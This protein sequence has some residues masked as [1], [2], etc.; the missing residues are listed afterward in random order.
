MQVAQAYEVGGAAA[1]SVLTEEQFFG[2][3]LEDLKDARAA[4]LLP[5]LRKDFV[6]DPYQVWEAWDAGADA[7]LLIV[8]AL[9]RRRAEDAARDGAG[10]GPRRAGRGA[11][12]RRSWS[13][14][15][16]PGA[17]AIGVNNRD[18]R[19]MEVR[20]ENAL[21]LAPLHPGRGR[22][23]GGE[24]HPRAGRRAAAARGGLRRVPGRRAPD[25][26]A[27]PRRGAGGAHPRLVDAALG[28][29]GRAQGREGRGQDLRH[30]DRRGRASR[31]RAP[32]P[33]R[34]VSSSCPAA[35]AASTVATARAIARALPP[36]VL[37]VGVFVDCRAAERRAHRVD[38]VGL[39]VVQLH[40]DETPEEVAR[41][42]A[43]RHQGGAGRTTRFT[44][45]DAL[46]YEG[47]AAGI[48]L[49]TRATP[50][51][52]PAAPASTFDWSRAREVRERASFL[53][54]A[55]GLTPENVGVALTAVRPDAVDVSSGVET[56][57][58][59]KDRGQGARVH[60]GGAERAMTGPA[61]PD[62]QGRFGPY[63]GRYVPETLMEPLRELTEAY[64]DGAPRSRR[65]A[66]ELPGAA[67]RLRRAPDAAHARGPAVGAARRAA[68]T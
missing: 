25:A 38:E 61:R 24:R 64:D 37:R 23:G 49:D 16:R 2:G 58:G 11:R 40:G 15:S 26:G 20:L 47:Q 5:A 19:T 65:S 7:V 56:A 42:S 29:P 32:A 12:P 55:G 54:L 18:L 28:R 1:L 9:D 34:S 14:R 4:T 27:D 46:R 10:G 53:V 6:V 66:R 43:A 68:S 22:G 45:A 31:R 30:H 13:A 50:G 33:T 36:F 44:A 62:A 63:G 51:G 3:A 52:R 60:P 35:R 41:L 17:R 57:P 67:A 59:R 39:D 8:A 48:L 21:E